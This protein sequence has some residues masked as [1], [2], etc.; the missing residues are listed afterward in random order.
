MTRA[1]GESPASLGFRWPAE[2][3]EHGA[4]WLSWPHN[5]ETWPGCLDEAEAA[6]AEIV[7]ALHPREAVRV[8]VGDAALE[9]RARR[10]LAE[11]GVDPAGGRG[12]HFHRI[13]TDDAYRMRSDALEQAIAEDRAA[14]WHPFCVVGTLATT[15][16][17]TGLIT[18]S[19]APDAA[20]DHSPSMK[21]LVCMRS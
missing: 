18:S 10:V 13:P 15:S 16:S 9:A 21:S 1:D 14:G 2:W 3:E 7:R 6:F 5:H 11:A 4:T 12:V 8:N 19:D 17:V 20:S